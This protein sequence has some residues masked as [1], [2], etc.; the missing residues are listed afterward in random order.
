VD[1][2]SKIQQQLL[3]QNDPETIQQIQA[4]AHA[5]A[6][7]MLT[8]ESGG[9]NFN[10]DISY[11]GGAH[12]PTHGGSQAHSHRAHSAL[13]TTSSSAALHGD[14]D[15]DDDDLAQGAGGKKKK[16]GM[17]ASASEAILRP[18]ASSAQQERKLNS[19]A[20]SPDLYEGVEEKTQ[21]S[22]KKQLVPITQ[23]GKS[24]PVSHGLSASNSTPA[25]HNSHSNRTL[26]PL[27]PSTAL[28]V[29]LAQS[30][31]SK[32]RHDMSRTETLD[33]VA[34]PDSPNAN[35]V[36]S[37]QHQAM[38]EYNPNLLASTT[39]MT[40]AF[41][42]LAPRMAFAEQTVKA[43]TWVK[44]MVAVNPDEANVVNYSVLRLQKQFNTLIAERNSRQTQLENLKNA[45]VLCRPSADEEE[46]NKAA[47]ERIKQLNMKLVTLNTR[48]MEAEEN[49][50]N[51]ELYI[52][53]MKEE[54][55]QLSKQI[56]HLR[57]LVTE[58]DRLL[59]KVER[60]SARV[61]AQKGEI[62]EELSHF[63]VDISEFIEFADKTVTNYRD[64]LNNNFK[65]NQRMDTEMEKKL[66][67]N[68][69]ASRS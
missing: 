16:R 41:Q 29:A 18:G 8:S 21:S 6:K 40:V 64:M 51:Y 61:L 66:D 68:I 5:A 37:D 57:Q 27:R 52:I 3:Q 69:D 46:L 23:K 24:G 56:E 63:Q 1:D 25:L 19:V 42:P 10:S 43:L 54:D 34:I 32:A 47:A 20:S 7:L 15:E 12:S 17:H 55:L 38:V 44:N 28:T 31:K 59:S 35:G 22:P 9:V 62:S 50:R 48:L 36:G 67:A 30:Q 53:R 39:A 65:K 14:D 60:M 2:V 33:G 49:K 26:G 11:A 13:A 45:L 58:Y 4:M